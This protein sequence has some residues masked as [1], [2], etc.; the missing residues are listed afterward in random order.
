LDGNRSVR[1]QPSNRKPSNRLMIKRD[2]RSSWQRKWFIVLMMVLTPSSCADATRRHVPHIETRQGN[3]IVHESW[4]HV[5]N[6]RRAEQKNDHEDEK[7][8]NNDANKNQNN[9]END[10]Q[11]NDANDEQTIYSQIGDTVSKIKQHFLDMCY[12]PPREWTT[13]HWG[14]FAGI[15]TLFLVCILWFCIAYVI[16][17]CCPRPRPLQPKLLSDN[18]DSYDSS[19]WDSPDTLSDLSPNTLS[20]SPYT[21]SDSPYTSEESHSS[22]EQSYHEYD[23]WKKCYIKY[24]NN[25]PPTYAG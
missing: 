6:W 16:P 8:Q 21:L 5:E 7:N 10:N 23:D 25:M 15:V 11:N 18:K 3:S 2:S 19:L 20:D 14:T 24:T 4:I 12:L 17:T 22:D 1:E 13:K 9:G